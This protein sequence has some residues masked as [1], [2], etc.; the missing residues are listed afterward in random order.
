MLYESKHEEH[1]GIN[2]FFH[3]VYDLYLKVPTI[4]AA[5]SVYR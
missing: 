4:H 1:P 2:K 5:L 3:E